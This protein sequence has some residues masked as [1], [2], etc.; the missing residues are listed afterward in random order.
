MK[1]TAIYLIFLFSCL[2]YIQNIN[3][4]NNYD[5]PRKAVELIEQGKF[6]EAK[7]E[8][9]TFQRKQPGNPLVLLYLGQIETD[10]NKALWYFKE[11]EILADSVLASEALFRRSEIVFSRGNHDEAKNLYELLTQKYPE[12]TFC[13]DAF[14]RLGLIKLSDGEPENAEEYFNTCLE[15]DK[16]GRKR[17]LAVTGL[18]ECYVA[19]EEW[20]KAK[21][22]ALEVIGEKDDFSAVT[23]RALD[24]IALSWRKLGNEKNAE[25]FTARLLKNYPNSY[26]AYAIRQIGKN[27]ASDSLYTFDSSFVFSNPGIQDESVPVN[28]LIKEKAKFTVQVGAYK[29]GARALKV[30]RMLEEKGFNARVDMKTVSD[31]H[32]FVV[33]VDYFM[34]REEADRMVKR[35]T[36]ETGEEAIVYILN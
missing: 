26:Q 28:D 8:L 30:Q 35:I 23:P 11:V 31:Q 20:E 25:E 2:L 12:S 4:Q 10:H 19:S 27:I 18:M 3:A 15:L 33:Q 24:V 29:E 16:S 9:N 36:R 34:T 13:I 1:K 5:V 21:D 7:V 14:Y 32:Y 6:E 17:L 22:T